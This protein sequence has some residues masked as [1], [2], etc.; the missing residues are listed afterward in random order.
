MTKV[1]K[2]KGSKKRKIREIKREIKEI[3]KEKKKI[4]ESDLEKDIEET[5]EVI[6]N[7][8]FHDFLQ[9]TQ[10]SAPVLTK[11]ETV[12]EPLETSIAMTSFSPTKETGIDYTT[13]NNAQNQ[14]KYT[15]AIDTDN[16]DE[17]KY[18]SEFRPPILRPIGSE[19]FREEILTSPKEIGMQETED[20]SRIETNIIE[21]KRKEPF[22]TQE[23]KY[24]E[25]RF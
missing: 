17:R 16:L 18:E 2:E 5:E 23:E 3:K 7:S 20:T 6:E 25:V 1:K 11:V 19:R 13:G 15:G 14:P 10:T 24:R 9:P 4:E 12:Q 21:Q 8:E 22:E